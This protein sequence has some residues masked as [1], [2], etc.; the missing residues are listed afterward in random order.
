MARQDEIN[1]FLGMLNALCKKYEV[2][3]GV[4]VIN[5]QPK[6]EEAKQPADKPKIKS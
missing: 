4:S 1:E 5:L 2:N 3:L 6:P